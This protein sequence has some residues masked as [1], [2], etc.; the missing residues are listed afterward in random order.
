V[1]PATAGR[2]ASQLGGQAA[3]AFVGNVFTLLIGFPLQIYVARMLGASGLGVF[4]LID[5]GVGLATTLMAFG[6]APTLVKFIPYHLERGENA[7]IRLLVAR[8]ATIL[9]VAG[10]L[11]YGFAMLG[12][13]VAIRYWPM[14]SEHRSAIHVM[15]FLMP[16]S[17]FAF[18]LQQ[19]LRGFQEIRYM[20][21][22]SS[23]LQL[24]VKAVVAVALLSAGFHLLGYVWAVLVSTACAVAWMAVG[25]CRKLAEMPSTA[26]AACSRLV[27]H[28][29]VTIRGHVRG[30][31]LALGVRIWTDSCWR[32][33]RTQSVGL[34]AVVKQ[35]QQ[36]PAIFLQISSQSRRPC[37]LRRTHAVPIANCRESIT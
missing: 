2:T 11:A 16:L 21:F 10:T 32:S 13:P 18:F 9:L 19:G 30:S 1:P 7:C 33:G 5:G 26:D 4:S 25:L 14:L 20:V 17:L 15:A 3:Y 6:Q 34:L 24:T 8:G 27:R 28:E 29:W 37:F 23:F 36:L 35:L 12:L 31:L 22:G